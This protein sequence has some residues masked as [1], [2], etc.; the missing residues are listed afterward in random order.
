VLDR[1]EIHRE[2]NKKDKSL[3]EVA[4]LR[5]EVNKTCKIVNKIL[6]MLPKAK[7]FPEFEDFVHQY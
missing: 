7:G 6:E 5:E 4:E 1:E 3:K 2:W